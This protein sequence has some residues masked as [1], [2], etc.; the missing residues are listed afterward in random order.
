MLTSAWYF[1]CQS[2]PSRRIGFA[3]STTRRWMGT[4]ACCI[5]IGASSIIPI[6][7]VWLFNACI[8]CGG[9]GKTVKLNCFAIAEL[10]IEMAAP[11]SGGATIN[12]LFILTFIFIAV[13]EIGSVFWTSVCWLIVV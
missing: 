7:C 9:I 5:F 8:F 11:V 2:M 4:L 1:L 6:T 10:M 3:D 12:W 13:V